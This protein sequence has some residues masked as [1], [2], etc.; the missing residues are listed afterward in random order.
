M[1]VQGISR[2][3]L[4]ISF[5]EGDIAYDYFLFHLYRAH[6]ST[7]ALIEHLNGQL[8]TKF[9]CLGGSGPRVKTPEKACD[10]I[11]ACCVL[12]NISKDDHIQQPYNHVPDDDHLDPVAAA[13]AD[14]VLGTAVRNYIVRNFCT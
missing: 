7:R 2:P 8:K 10:V 9:L 12:F 3:L 13:A 1:P 6:R 14:D 11:K 5:Q 4:A